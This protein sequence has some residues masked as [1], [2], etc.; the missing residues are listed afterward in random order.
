M[1]RWSLAIKLA[2]T[3]IIL[4]WLAH[5]ADFSTIA[6]VVLRADMKF[7]LL[8]TMSLALQPVLGAVRWSVILDRLGARHPFQLVA[9]WTYAGVFVNQVLPA[10]VGGDGVRIWLARSSGAGLGTVVGSVVLDR[11]SMLGGLLLVLLLSAP[12][13]VSIFDGPNAVIVFFGLTA[14]VLTAAGILLFADRFPPR[15]LANRPIALLARFAVQA[16]TVYLHPQSALAVVILSLAGVA[17]LILS[18]AVFAKAFGAVAGVGDMSMVLAPVIV[19]STLP[20]S[21]GGWGTREVAS[22][23]MLGPLGVTSE[24]AILSSLWLGLSSIFISLPGAFTY[25]ARANPTPSPSEPPERA[26]Q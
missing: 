19:A 16:R 18:F 15:L 20:I 25:L 22:I 4:G 17:N 21:I 2:L 12:W 14:G 10:T 3:T 8:G 11:V 1:V 7:L 24:I 26:L 5:K 13:Y 9:A 23:A 6:D